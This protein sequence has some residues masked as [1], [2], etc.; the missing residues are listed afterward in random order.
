MLKHDEN[1]DVFAVSG[2][3]DNRNILCSFTRRDLW[4]PPVSGYEESRIVQ[5]LLYA[6]PHRRARLSRLGLESQNH[7]LFE[8]SLVFAFF[9]FFDL[10]LPEFSS[11]VIL[12][13]KSCNVTVVSAEGWGI[14]LSAI[15]SHSQM[16]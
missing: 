16:F 5:L 15:N 1:E 2:S 12:G 9:F 10:R 13:S 8:F 3:E 4:F 6:R 11:V 14:I 7:I